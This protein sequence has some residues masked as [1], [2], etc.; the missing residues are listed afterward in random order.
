[1][2]DQAGSKLAFPQPDPVGQI[3]EIEP[4][5]LGER[6]LGCDFRGVKNAGSHKDGGEHCVVKREDAKDAASIEASEI[7][8]GLARVEQNPSYEESGKNKKEIYPHP[9]L[10]CIS[11][12]IKREAV[13][14]WNL[15]ANVMEEYEDDRN[16]A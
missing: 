4:A 14:D 6:Q 2:R 11:A 16:G 5:I 3:T 8:A 7:V 9:A 15:A 1:M 13:D 12:Q 10:G